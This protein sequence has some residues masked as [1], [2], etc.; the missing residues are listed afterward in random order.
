MRWGG[1]IFNHISYF[2]SLYGCW[3]SRRLRQCHKVNCSL[4][5]LHSTVTEKIS[6]IRSFHFGGNSNYEKFPPFWLS[7]SRSAL[8]L[9]GTNRKQ[10]WV[11]WHNRRPIKSGSR[12]T[13]LRPISGLYSFVG[14]FI[15]PSM[16]YTT[17]KIR[18]MSQPLLCC[19]EKYTF[20]L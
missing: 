17:K 9:S 14:S 5:R 11:T 3:G 4:V 16:T 12:D 20:I 6:D 19:F 13:K 10:E 8:G 1:D 2:I 15:S 7:Q 18:Y